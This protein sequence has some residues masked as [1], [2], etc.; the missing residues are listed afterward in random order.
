MFT[1]PADFPILAA[2]VRAKLHNF[3][4][5]LQ[6]ADAKLELAIDA[7]EDTG[8]Y[9]LDM[10]D[11]IE[12]QGVARTFAR[13]M[14][15]IIGDAPPT[16]PASVF[17]TL[18]EYDNQNDRNTAHAEG[19]GI[20]LR[21]AYEMVEA[22]RNLAFDADDDDNPAYELLLATGHSFC[23]IES[24]V[25]GSIVGDWSEKILPSLLAGEKMPT[26]AELH[27]ERLPDLVELEH[28]KMMRERQEKADAAAA[29]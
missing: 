28:R 19:A 29:E 27:A 11:L 10:F 3:L 12:A 26:H 8:D 14:P 24:M 13:I 15:G 22:A 5:A 9:S 21:L 20:A 2:A 1:P 4:L 18:V 16:L 6:A 25:N 23:A 17:R 7:Y